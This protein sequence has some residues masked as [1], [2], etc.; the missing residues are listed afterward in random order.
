M[1]ILVATEELRFGGAQTFALRLAQALAEAGHKVYLYSLYHNLIEHDLVRRL[2]PDVPVL[3]YQPS[4]EAGDTLLQRS[5]AW[6]ERK[7][8]RLAL[9]QQ[10]LT[11][12]LRQCLQQY[13]IDVVS[14]NTF[15][16]DE[17]MALALEA[18]P[19]IPL[20]VTMHGDYEQFWDFYTRGQDYVLPDYPQRLART[21][22]RINAVAYLADQNLRV[23]APNIVPTQATRHLLQQR[24]YNGMAAH[25][26]EEQ[27]RFS[28]A[29][30]GI[31]PEAFVVGMVA[32]GVAEKGWQ[33]LITAFEQLQ[34]EFPQRPL[35]LLLV[36]DSAYLSGLKQQYSTNAAIQ[37]LGF[38]NN[39]VD[40]IASFDVGV[41][42]SSLKESLPNSIAEYLFCGKPVVSTEVGE[43]RN[44]LRTGLTIG[45]DSPEAGLLVPFPPQGQQADPQALYQALRRYL[46]EPEL[47]AEHQS[48]ANQAFR[49]FEMQQCIHAYLDLYQRAEQ[50]TPARS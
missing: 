30:L 41:L 28:R 40:C 37:F 15:K 22:R 1:N 3:S 17:A 31:S 14:S 19:H 34:R 47:L 7:G 13:Q 2:A 48:M 18:L 10:Q 32:R 6:L 12:H 5:E 9:R 45:D 8:R 26:S 50:A 16:S 43:I 23:L 33:P 35:N 49:K 27:P 39:P 29:A 38:A 24:I 20:V 42:A 46:I 21:F 11:R 4:W 25:Y 36:G 44:M